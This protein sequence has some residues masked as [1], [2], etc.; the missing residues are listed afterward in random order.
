MNDTS[1]APHQLV[2]VSARAAHCEIGD[3]ETIPHWTSTA[4]LTLGIGTFA[5]P[6][7][8]LAIA[9]VSLASVAEPPPFLLALTVGLLVL[10]MMIA[11]LYVAFAG[12]NPRLYSPFAWQMAMVFLGPIAMPAYWVIHVWNA[13]RATGEA[14]MGRHHYDSLEARSHVGRLGAPLGPIV[15]PLLPL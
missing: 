10:H 13:P 8:A 4:R 1:E 6:M 12:Q 9:I 7:Y 2:I 3:R 15:T 11:L 14:S 5:T